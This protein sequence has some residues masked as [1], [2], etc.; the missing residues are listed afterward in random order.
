MLISRLWWTVG[1]K[2]LDI[3]FC[4]FHVKHLQRRI[5][6]RSRSLKN[7]VGKARM[8]S[9]Q[10][11]KRIPTEKF[12]MTFRFWLNVKMTQ[13]F[14]HLSSV[15]ILAHW[16]LHTHLL[17]NGSNSIGVIQECFGTTSLWL[18][19]DHHVWWRSEP[20]KIHSAFE[21]SIVLY[22]FW[23]SVE[24]RIQEKCGVSTLQ[25]SYKMNYLRLTLSDFSLT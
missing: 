5:R 10:I 4:T 21:M 2:T 12:V 13:K 7:S 17:Q 14:I 3:P 15:K 6:Q 23:N 8:L 25:R 19:V 1:S 20:K 18:S 11:P 16:P 24:Y 9:F 22:N